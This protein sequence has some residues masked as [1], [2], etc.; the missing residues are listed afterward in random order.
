MTEKEVKQDVWENFSDRQLETMANCFACVT[1][2]FN[3]I[4]SQPHVLL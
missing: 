3:Q 1:K 4:L 2:G